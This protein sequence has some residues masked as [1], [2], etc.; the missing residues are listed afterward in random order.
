LSQV[1]DEK[2]RGAL[3]RAAAREE[4]VA[5]LLAGELT[6]FEAAARFRDLNAATP[7]IAHNIRL[8][9]PG[10]SA[11]HAVC[12]QVITFVEEEMRRCA[13][14]KVRV[15]RARLEDEL[16]DHLRRHG[17]VCLPDSPP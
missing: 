1:L 14:E 9:F 2:L 12:R 10:L 7:E 15:V 13:P 4:I 8:R 3:Q 11:E 16:A 5:R 17:R 6:L